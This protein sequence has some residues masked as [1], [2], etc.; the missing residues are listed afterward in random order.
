MRGGGV[1]GD[2]QAGEVRVQ[3]E[4][5]KNMPLAHPANQDAAA[6]PWEIRVTQ[7]FM[8]QNQEVNN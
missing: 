2:K 1:E 4:R 5:E 7:A 3:K 6:A 8:K